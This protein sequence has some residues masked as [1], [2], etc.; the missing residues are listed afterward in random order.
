M[1]TRVALHEGQDSAVYARRGRQSF[2]LT[3]SQKLRPFTFY[4]D[5]RPGKL[6]EADHLFLKAFPGA[7]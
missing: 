7:S 6:L 2:L 3:N 1:R 5:G 4:D